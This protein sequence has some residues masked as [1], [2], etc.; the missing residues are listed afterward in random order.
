MVNNPPAMQETWAL[1]LGQEDPLEKGIAT[2]SRI[3]AGEFYGQR[4]LVGYSSWGHK[5]SNMTEPLNNKY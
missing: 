3:I 1:P 5:E 2:Q 4:G